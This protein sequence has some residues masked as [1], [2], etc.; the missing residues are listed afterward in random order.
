MEP[1]QVAAVH[2]RKLEHVP[3]LKTVMTNMMH[4]AAMTLLQIPS[5]QK[6]VIAVR[7]L[8]MPWERTAGL[9]TQIMMSADRASALQD[10]IKVE[11]Q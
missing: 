7:I 2:K 9:P 11:E 4:E 8:Y 3:L 5:E 1:Q 10:K 6:I